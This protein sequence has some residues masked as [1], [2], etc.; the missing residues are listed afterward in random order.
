MTTPIGH[1]ARLVLA[2]LRQRHDPLL[3]QPAGADDG[4][5]ACFPCDP[6]LMVP[7][8]ILSAMLRR[9]L[10]EVRE[11][12]G[13]AGRLAYVAAHGALDDAYSAADLERHNGTVRC[14]ERSCATVLARGRRSLFPKKAA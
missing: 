4:P 11:H 7:M 10:V 2:L 5:G 13:S 1:H 6:A 14:W 8:N 9:G 12:E 3:Y